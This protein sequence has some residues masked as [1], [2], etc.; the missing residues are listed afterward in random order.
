LT[1][2]SIK[3]LV[4][5][6]QKGDMEAFNTLY[7]KYHS[8]LYSN[9]L[10]L[11]RDEIVAEDLLQETFVALWEKRHLLDPNQEISGWLFVVSYNKSVS[12]LKIKLKESMTKSTSQQIDYGS[13][14]RVEIVENQINVLEKGILLLSP[15]KRMVFDLCKLQRKTYEEAARELNISK[16]TVKEYLS[17]A[18]DFLKEFAKREPSN[19]LKN[20]LLLASL[21]KIQFL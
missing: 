17:D 12:F 11:C 4:E 15:Q 20:F 9:I 19:G 1:Y 14:D 2:F 8:A 7:L 6:L 16:H 13:D 5:R 18:M 3:E 21:F 10:R